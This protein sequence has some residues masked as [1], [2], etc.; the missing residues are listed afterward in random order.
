MNW[1]DLRFLI[2]LARAGSLAAAAR[3]L[4]VDQTTVARRLRALEDTLGTPLMERSA[5]HWQPT[6]VGARVLARAEQIARDVDGIARLADPEADSVSGQVRLTSVTAIIDGLLIPALPRLYARHPAL[7]LELLA[8]NES[9]DVARREAD[10]ALRLARP[11]AGDFLMRKLADCAF[12][13][14]AT[15]SSPADAPWLAYHAALAHTPEMRWLAEHQGDRPIRLRSDS[16]HGLARAAAQGLG[17]AVLP[18]FVGDAEPG[19]VRTSGLLLKREVWM[20]IHPDARRLARVNA[21]AAWL[22]ECFQTSVLQND[23][24]LSDLADKSG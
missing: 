4:A 7:H 10:I 19:L 5:G 14:Y 11:R 23:G 24:N 17:A 16:L 1:D 3:R 22:E 18:C 9:L 2:E 20:L 13:C 21:V 8:S 6:P 15:P 12:A